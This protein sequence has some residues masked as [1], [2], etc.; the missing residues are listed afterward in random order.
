MTIKI[1]TIWN[2]P[3]WL[4][5]QPLTE[6]VTAGRVQGCLC[7]LCHTPVDPAHRTV[8]VLDGEGAW[9][10]GDPIPP[11]YPEIVG[12]PVEELVCSNCAP[13]LPAAYLSGSSKTPRWPTEW[14]F[15]GGFK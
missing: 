10:H 13:K 9:P 12:D 2:D 3:R 6:P 7:L 15:D 11:E 8:Q 14:D 5:L 1:E 4:E